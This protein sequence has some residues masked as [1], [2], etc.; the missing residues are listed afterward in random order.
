M[1]GLFPKAKKPEPLPPPPP[2]PPPAA[3]PEVGPEPAE[4]AAKRARRRAGWQ[5]TII[6]GSLVPETTG[7]KTKLGGE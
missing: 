7:K 2:P 3:I 1:G 4:E 6:T 5:R